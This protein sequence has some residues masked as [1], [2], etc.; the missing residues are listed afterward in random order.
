MA[1]T[2]APPA[3]RCR[4]SRPPRRPTEAASKP[5][6]GSSSSQSGAGAK[7]KFKIASAQVARVIVAVVQN[8]ANHTWRSRQEHDTNGT[9][10]VELTVFDKDFVKVLSTADNKIS[11]DSAPVTV[12]PKA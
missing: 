12:K 4:A 3:S 10:E 7:A 8:N 5:R 11:K 2:T 9:L 1:A 6:V